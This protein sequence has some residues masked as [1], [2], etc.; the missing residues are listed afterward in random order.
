MRQHSKLQAP[1]LQA[2]LL[3]LSSSAENACCRQGTY[4]HICCAT[5]TANHP[6]SAGPPK[7]IYTPPN[8]HLPT[9][10]S[11]SHTVL[12]HSSNSMQHLLRSIH[13]ACTLCT[14]ETC[15]CGT[16]P[17]KLLLRQHV[18]CLP[19]PVLRLLSATLQHT[20]CSR[21]EHAAA[22]HYYTTPAQL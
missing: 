18:T 15:A 7:A 11:T 20:R 14:H 22:L 5:N 8:L 21:G 16:S 10:Y 12:M 13:K 3:L 9:P 4:K 2:A 19:L 6:T 1:R 17:M